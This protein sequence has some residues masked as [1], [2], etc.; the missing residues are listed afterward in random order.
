MKP[1]LLKNKLNMISSVSS[2]SK[3]PHARIGLNKT[4]VYGLHKN[5]NK[6]S[7]NNQNLH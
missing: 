3:S 2:M 5:I 1:N 4:T 6:P 7:L